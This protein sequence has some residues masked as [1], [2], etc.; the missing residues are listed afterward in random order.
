MSREELVRLL[1][2]NLYCPKECEAERAELRI[3]AAKGM[4][5]LGLIVIRILLGWFS[6][7]CGWLLAVTL[8]VLTARPPWTSAILPAIVLGTILILALTPATSRF[9]RAWAD[10][11]LL[12][13]L[14][15]AL[16]L[17][18][19]VVLQGQIPLVEQ[20]RRNAMPEGERRA[21]E[22][23][24]RAKAESQ[25]LSEAREEAERRA[26][27][28]KTRRAERAQ[29]EG[30]Q[31]KKDMAESDQE[32]QAFYDTLGAPK[33]LY[34]CSSEHPLRAVGATRGTINELLRAAQA[35]C[36]TSSFEIV[37]RKD[38]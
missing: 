25:R 6:A 16:V 5:Q 21:L 14:R 38:N 7:I 27:D 1:K 3:K 13:G 28:E 2:L 11:W 8:I 30:A 26:E 31:R 29:S 32:Q 15:V 20:A 23:Q 10:G 19:L 22:A 18:G 36:S 34:R 24:D 17:V 12:L 33:L 37:K 9:M 4:G 35:A